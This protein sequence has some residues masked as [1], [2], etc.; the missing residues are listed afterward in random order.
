MK[1]KTKVILYVFACI[2]YYVGL[3]YYNESQTETICFMVLDTPA[4]GHVLC[5][6]DTNKNG[7]LDY[8]E[9]T[10]IEKIEP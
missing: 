8:D 9:V 10:K 4:T 3:Y 1:T 5:G 2:C 6:E 7:K